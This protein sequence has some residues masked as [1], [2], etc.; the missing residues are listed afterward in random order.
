MS[1]DIQPNIEPVRLR[2]TKLA[3][4]LGVSRVT[5]DA[6]L[7]RAEPPPPLPDADGAYSVEEVADYIATIKGDESKKKGASFW[8]AEKRRL[9]CE[10]IAL[11]L[12]VASGKFL[13]REEASKTIVP[14]MAELAELL[15]KE[16]ELVNPAR[17]KG[18]D[19]VECAAINRK[20]VDLV[21]G[22]F[23]QGVKTFTDA[24]A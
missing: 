18:R 10:E 6:Y 24:A 4:E 2:K 11:R 19:Q 5:L 12:K 21:I 1:G 22:R 13:S 20:S 3:P 9:Q 14:L 16:F 8:E 15:T 17:Y 7:N 23:R